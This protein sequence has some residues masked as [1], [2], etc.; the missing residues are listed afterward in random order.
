MFCQISTALIHTAALSRSKLAS[1]ME[2]TR[3]YLPLEWEERWWREKEMHKRTIED[4]DEE[5]IER[6]N[7]ELRRIVA[8]NDSRMGLTGSGNRKT[9]ATEEGTG[10]N[11][12]KEVEHEEHAQIYFSGTYPKEV[13]LVFKEFWDS[14][15]L[16]DLT[17]VTTN[18]KSFQVHSTILAAVSSFIQDILREDSNKYVQMR[19]VSLGPDVHHIGLK[20]V[21]EFAYTGC[22]LSLNK[23]SMIL[24]RAAAQSMGVPRLLQLCDKNETNNEEQN[25]LS[26][27]QM[28]ITAEAIQRMWADRVGCDVTLDMDGA[29]FH[30]QYIIPLTA[31]FRCCLDI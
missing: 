27:E 21:L 28:K 15:V 26:V 16:T 5:G 9:G 3:H 22:V 4:G 20:G 13:F 14:S 18:E 19:T 29:S 31:I 1:V 23:D 24:I 30:G 6:A 17:L 12:N 8:Y 11:V 10:M 25:G 7:R 2:F